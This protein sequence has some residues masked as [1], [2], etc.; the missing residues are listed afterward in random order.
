MQALARER[1]KM[2]AYCSDGQGSLGEDDQVDACNS[3]GK[4]VHEGTRQ[5]LHGGQCRGQGDTAG[6]GLV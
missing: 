6:A 5:R 2:A 3:K 4:A 1:F